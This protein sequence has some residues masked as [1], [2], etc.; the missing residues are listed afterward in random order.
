[1]KSFPSIRFLLPVGIS[2]IL[3]LSSCRYHKGDAYTWSGTADTVTYFLKSKGRHVNDKLAR[4]IWIHGNKGDDCTVVYLSD[5]AD[6]EQ[7]PSVLLFNSALPDLN[8]DMLKKGFMGTFASRQVITYLVVTRDD[9]EH[10]L[11]P[12]K[13]H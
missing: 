3:L 11:K 8:D 2:G 6:V 1:M 9:L 5:S 4:L 13:T 12:L 10:K 7:R